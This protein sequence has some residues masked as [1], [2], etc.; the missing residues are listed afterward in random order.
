MQATARGS[1][2]A[3][4]TTWD[5]TIVCLP[6]TYPNVGEDAITIPRKK[7]PILARHGLIGKIHLESDWSEDA[8]FAEV[9]SVFKDAMGADLNF[10]FKFL[11]PTGG[12]SKSLTKPV[13]STTFKWTSKEVAGRADS[14]I[15]ILAEKELR[16]EVCNKHTAI[17]EH[18]LKEARCTICC[19]LNFDCI[20]N[21]CTMQ[22]TFW[23][24]NDGD[25]EGDKSSDIDD[26]SLAV[27]TPSA[28]VMAPEVTTSSSSTS[29]PYQ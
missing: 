20:L 21:F 12:G 28:S 4:V 25:V 10:P 24:V 27:T 9:R 14:T 3:K 11:V 16:N 1:K 23:C 15:Y 29:T 5:R 22:A 8:I 19:N 13:V 17:I 18:L 2:S 6:Q 7:R 26:D